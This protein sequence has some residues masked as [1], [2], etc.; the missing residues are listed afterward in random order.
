MTTL[1]TSDRMYRLHVHEA[2]GAPRATIVVSHAM[3][4]SSAYLARPEGR[5]LCDYLAGAGFRV[6]RVDLSGYAP[7]RPVTRDESAAIGFRLWVDDMTEVFSRARAEQPH[8]PVYALG[9]CVGGLASLVAVG[10]TPEVDGIITVSPAVWGFGSSRWQ[11]IRERIIVSMGCA[12]QR[13]IG[14]FPSRVVRLGDVDAPIGHLREYRSWMNGKKFQS[15][16]GDLDYEACLGNVRVPHLLVWGIRDRSMS[17]RGNVAWVADRLGTTT[18]SRMDVSKEAGFPF[19]GDHVSVIY[20][21]R[22]AES[23]WPRLVSW[24]QEL[25]T[26]P[27]SSRISVA[28]PVLGR[29]PM[30][31]VEPAVPAAERGLRA[32]GAS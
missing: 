10:N 20:G 21:K 19:D 6:L 22:A 27:R 2:V 25:S 15:P 17:P 12:L 9:H 28:S 4:T 1:A 3:F 31:H 23:V 8:L 5:G 14:R 16:T 24:F 26:Q 11:G 13:L 29:P 7:A 32:G 18:A 30:A